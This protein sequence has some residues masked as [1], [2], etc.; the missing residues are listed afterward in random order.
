MG[1]TL[2]VNQKSMLSTRSLILFVFVWGIGCQSPAEDYGERPVAVQKRAV[3]V[4]G[5]PAPIGPYTPIVESGDFLFLSGQIG[6][7]SKTG[8]LVDGGVT[9]ETTQIMDN[10]LV[11]LSA[12]DASFA[13]VVQAQV[14]LIDITDYAAMN[15]VY[16]S[17]FKGLVPPARAAVAVTALPGGASV[18]IM[19][20]ARK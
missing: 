17:Y 2:I 4:D 13:D 7:N 19:M 3:Q 11:L 1:F 5:I 10:I 9:E 12:G 20:T 16:A 15:E 18:E 6:K 14:F 8:K